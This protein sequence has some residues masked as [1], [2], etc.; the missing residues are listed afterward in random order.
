MFGKAAAAESDR[1]GG[2]DECPWCKFMKGGP[3][4][5]VFEVGQLRSYNYMLM[6][7]L[8]LYTISLH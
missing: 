5:N 2:E 3:C 6:P 4:R 7:W 8:A 1:S